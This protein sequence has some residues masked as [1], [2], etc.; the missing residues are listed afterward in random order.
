MKKLSTGIILGLMIALTFS[1]KTIYELKNT[2]AEV[3]KIR[4]LAI[5]TD[6]LPSKDYDNLGEI[7]LSNFSLRDTDYETCRNALITK[8]KEKYKD[9]EGLIITCNNRYSAE[10]IAFKK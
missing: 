4:G 9:V 1:F 8:S 3:Q 5:F 10:V 6:C 2:T 7:K